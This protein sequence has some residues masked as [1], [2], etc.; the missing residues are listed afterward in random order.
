MQDRA[1]QQATMTHHGTGL[2]SKLGRGR[3][4][5]PKSSGNGNIEESPTCLFSPPAAEVEANLGS[6]TTIHRMR[7]APDLICMYYVKLR[8]AYDMEGS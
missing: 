6:V 3:K 5:G 1:W 4:R 8:E 7:E 2:E